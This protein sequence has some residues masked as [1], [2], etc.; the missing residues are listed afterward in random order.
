MWSVILPA[1]GFAVFQIPA[2]LFPNIEVCIGFTPPLLMSQSTFPSAPINTKSSSGI[3]L[4]NPPEPT[5]KAQC[6]LRW[7]SALA[8]VQV[9]VEQRDG[10]IYCHCNAGQ[11]RSVM[12][13]ILLVSL[14]C[15]IS[16]ADS[17]PCHSIVLAFVPSYSP[18][19]QCLS[20]FVQALAKSK[21]YSC[22]FFGIFC[23]LS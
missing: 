10:P 14:G 15:N 2:A 20:C 11:V 4:Q 17:A 12:V 9:W 7:R 8:P 1:L 23:C 3:S 21:L 22:V 18:Y 5:P 19:C 6:I 13:T 16:I